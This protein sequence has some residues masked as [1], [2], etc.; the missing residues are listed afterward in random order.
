MSDD[1][2]RKVRTFID[3][4]FAGARGKGDEESLLESGVI[5]SLGVLE[6]AGWVGDTCNVELTD[7]DLH[8]DNFDSV[9]SLVRFLASKAG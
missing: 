7:D 8:P 6:L 3:A 5:D 9:S 2:H 4:R 1:L